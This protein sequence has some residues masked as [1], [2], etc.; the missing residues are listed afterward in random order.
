MLII[1]AKRKKNCLIGLTELKKW[2]RKWDKI[3]KTQ[4]L[5]R[6]K[7]P[8]LLRSFW[9]KKRPK[10]DVRQLDIKF[11][12]VVARTSEG[13][14]TPLS[15]TSVC[16]VLK[17]SNLQTQNCLLGLTESK[18]WDAKWDK[19]GKPQKL[20]GEKKTGMSTKS[21][22][23]RPGVQMRHVVNWGLLWVS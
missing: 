21:E 23:K 16:N 22:T 8:S 15:S 9:D 17:T 18:K 6:W 7:R 5:V 20:V 4:R 13:V 19:I 1:K 3:V 2:D 10:S 14:E 12:P 11:Y